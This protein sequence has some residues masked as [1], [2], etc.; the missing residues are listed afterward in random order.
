M[1]IACERLKQHLPGLQP[2]C[3]IVEKHLYIPIRNGRRPSMRPP[4]LAGNGS[5]QSKLEESVT[6]H[7]VTGDEEIPDTDASDDD[8]MDVE[9]EDVGV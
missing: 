3:N 5:L 4:E 6:V 1:T 8:M 2:I 9:E 7:D